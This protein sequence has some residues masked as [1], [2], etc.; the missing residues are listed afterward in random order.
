MSEVATYT[1]V[2]PTYGS[3]EVLL[4]KEDLRLLE[5]CTWSVWN[6]HGRDIFYVRRTK[7]NAPKGFENYFHRLVMNAKKG[8][9]VDHK[10]GNTLDNRKENLRFVSQ[11]ENGL[12]RAKLNK[13]N[14]TGAVGVR[15][16]RNRYYP[17]IR[18][19]RKQEWFGG[20]ATLEE[21]VAKR[22]SVLGEIKNEK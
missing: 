20:Y 7:R 16:I 2:S 12:N 11:S 18:I 19:N 1:I 14:T 17:Y 13:N 8:D 10:N 15:K 21:A 5:E 4:D 22:E 9:I 6:D 3:K